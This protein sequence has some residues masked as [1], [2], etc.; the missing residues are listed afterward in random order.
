MLLQELRPVV[1]DLPE[2]LH[3]LRG[4]GCLAADEL[5]GQREGDLAADVEEGLH[6]GVAGPQ[7]D[8]LRLMQSKECLQGWVG[9]GHVHHSLGV[10]RGHVHHSLGVGRG[11]CTTHRGWGG[12]CAPLIGGGEGA[13]APLIGGGEGHVHHS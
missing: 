7:L 3:E 8:A 9:R 11:M 2:P 6:C 12:A 1:E 10:G 4:V 5:H 13:C